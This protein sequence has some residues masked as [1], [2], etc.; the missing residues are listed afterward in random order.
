MRFIRTMSLSPGLDSEGTNAEAVE[1][2][3]NWPG[4][5]PLDHR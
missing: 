3:E 4:P 2:R 1:W 5:L